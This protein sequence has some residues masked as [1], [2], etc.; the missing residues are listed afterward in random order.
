VDVREDL[1]GTTGNLGG[2]GQ[3]LEERG[4]LWTHGGDSGWNP[5]INWSNSSGLGWGLDLVLDANVA[6]LAQ[7]AW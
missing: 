4:L 6:G 2:D 3:S 7:I 1:N 5:H